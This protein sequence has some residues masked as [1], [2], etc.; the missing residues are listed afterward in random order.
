MRR[1]VCG[2]AREAASKRLR[3]VAEATLTPIRICW[4]T[5][6]ENAKMTDCYFEKKDW[7]ACAAEVW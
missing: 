2:A 6:D 5:P 7:R 4:G 1:Y 3:F